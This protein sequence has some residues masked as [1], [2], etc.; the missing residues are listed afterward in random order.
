MKTEELLNNLL[1]ST[2]NHISRVRTFLQQEDEI[3]QRKSGEQW[4]A[5][6]CFDHLNLYFDFY[7]PHLTKQIEKSGSQ[8]KDDFRPGIIGNYFAE[9]MLVKPA[10]KKMKTPKDKNPAG[11]NLDRQTVSVL[12]KNLEKLALLTEQ[13]RN[14]NLEKTKIPVSISKLIRLK[15]GDAL[16]FIVNHNER[17]LQ[18]AERAV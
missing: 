2:E 8:P 12:I 10:M 17:H 4:S 16:R 18:Q 5:L 7:L 3:N 1:K 11:K 13:A 14:V 9:S 6:E 15:L